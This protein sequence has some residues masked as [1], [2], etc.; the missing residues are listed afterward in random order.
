M[1]WRSS[2]VLTVTLQMLGMV[3]YAFAQGLTPQFIVVFTIS[4]AVMLL[5]WAVLKAALIKLDKYRIRDKLPVALRNS[6][7]RNPDI[8]GQIAMYAAVSLVTILFF[9]LVFGPLLGNRIS[10]LSALLVLTFLS[11]LLFV[12]S[13]QFPNARGYVIPYDEVKALLANAKMDDVYVHLDK[14]VNFFVEIDKPDL[15][16]CIKEA[17][18]ALESYLVQQTGIRDFDKAADKLKG[19]SVGQIHPQLVQGMKGL[20]TYRGDADGVAHA[21]LQG[22]PVTKSEAQLVLDLVASYLLYCNNLFPRVTAQEVPAKSPP[23]TS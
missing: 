6:L 12:L 13:T 21:T 14:A 17:V 3:G 19:K 1:K 7:R 9:N 2:T 4:G 8:A 10:S 11:A 23:A 22:N 15:A 18:C 5:L 16:N 20:Y